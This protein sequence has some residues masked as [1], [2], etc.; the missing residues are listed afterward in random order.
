MHK[1]GIIIAIDGPAGSGKSTTARMVAKY[2]KYLYIDT[3]AM[4]RAVAL[5]WL[6]SGYEFEASAIN[7]LMDTLKIELK[8]GENGQIVILNSEDV[9]SEIRKPEVTKY[10]S[11]ISAFEYVREKLVAQQREMGSEGGI[12]MDGRDI[13][14]VVFPNAELKIF[15][16]ASLEARAERRKKELAQ[17]GISESLESIIEG[18]RIRDLNDS[19]REISPLRMAEDAV[20]LDTTILTIEEQCEFVTRK[21][22][23]IINEFK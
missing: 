2:F 7:E 13:G 9:T 21:A 10:S 14:T 1:N 15:L 16:V 20:K 12:V 11:P 17:K 19:S 8:Q 22:L 18:I 4:Y 5:A 3:G 23:K 6:R